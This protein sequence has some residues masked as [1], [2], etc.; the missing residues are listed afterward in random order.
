MKAAILV[1]IIACAPIAAYALPASVEGA[2]ARVESQCSG[3]KRL[4]ECRPHSTIA[5]TGRPSLH[6]YC[7]AVDFRVDSYGCAYGA[8]ADWQHGLS[9]DGPSQRHIHLS[10]GTSIGRSEGRFY[11]G[12]GR[13]HAHRHGNRRHHNHQRRH[14]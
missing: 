12:G 13:R 4:S 8:L 9:M 5:G 7:L 1:A 2:L 11:H 14:T 10:D 3:F 6:R